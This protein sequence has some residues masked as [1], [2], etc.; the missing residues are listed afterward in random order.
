MI[1]FHLCCKEH[2]QSNLP[3][4]DPKFKI[5]IMCSSD[6]EVFKKIPYGGGHFVS[7]GSDCLGFKV[8]QSFCN[9]IEFSITK[10]IQN[11]VSPTF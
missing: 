4:L 7:K 3:S 11:A 10:I 6:L 9:I 1:T 5:L 2:E 8:T